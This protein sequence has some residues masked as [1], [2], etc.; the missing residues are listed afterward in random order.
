M[1]KKKTYIQVNI[2]LDDKNIPEKI[3]WTSKDGNI[4]NKECDSLILSIWSNNKKET[5]RIELWTKNMPV[6]SM[7]KFFYDIFISMSNAYERATLNKKLSK[8]IYDFGIFFA[9]KVNLKKNEKIK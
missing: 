5:S 7:N 9:E 6:N 3:F 2:Y 4:F 1:I 8:Y